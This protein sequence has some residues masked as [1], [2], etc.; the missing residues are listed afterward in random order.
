VFIS[1]TSEIGKFPRDH[2]FVAA[3]RQAVE[4]AGCEPVEMGDFPPQVHPSATVCREKIETCDVFVAL[5]GFRYGSTVRRLPWNRRVSYVEFEWQ[6]AMKRGLPI[7]ILLLDEAA[8][9]PHDLFGDPKFHRRQQRLRDQMGRRHHLRRFGTD[10]ELYELLLSGLAELPPPPPEEPEPTAL[11]PGPVPARRPREWLRRRRYRVAA[12]AA[13][14]TLSVLATVI[15]F[16]PKSPD[17]GC[18]ISTEL[19]VSTSVDTVDVLRD[20]AKKFTVETRVGDCRQAN[21]DVVVASPDAATTKAFTHKWKDEKGG[22]H[23]GWPREDLRQVGPYPHV[24]MP[25]S[26]LEVD[27]AKA[28][29]PAGNLEITFT[30]L[31]SVMSS[32]LVLAV[33]EGIASNPDWRDPSRLSLA[34]VIRRAET[35]TGTGSLRLV[36][37]GPEASTDSLLSTEALYQAKLGGKRLDPRKLSDGGIRLKLHDLEQATV[38][39]GGIEEPG[40]AL[41]CRAAASV[42]PDSEVALMSEQRIFEYNTESPPGESCGTSPRRLTAVY[43]SD[44]APLLD[45][46]FVLV[47]GARWGN[48]KSETAAR[49]FHD[50]LLKDDAQRMLAEKGFRPSG[51]KAFDQVPQDAGIRREPPDSVFVPNLAAVRPDALVEAWKSARRP[52]RVLFVVDVSGSMAI[53]GVDGVTPLD[54]A[55]PAI[56]SA[57]DLVGDADQV[58]LWIFT[59][60]LDGTRDYRE[61]VG[62]GPAQARGTAGTRDQVQ[63][64]LAGLH[65]ENGDTG[66]FDTIRDGIAALR[67]D[68]APAADT[69]TNNALVVFTD[70]RNDDPGGISAGRLVGELNPRESQPVRV[71]ILAFGE[72]NCGRSDLVPLLGGGVKCLDVTAVGV[73]KA[74]ERVGAG[75]WGVD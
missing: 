57:L 71:D 72:A 10:R 63:Q 25:R 62:L 29:R 60:K 67:A 18:G 30:P 37:D 14:A 38:P 22:Q 59:T 21:V 3:A 5:V 68:K 31:T 53:P 73:G 69:E 43:P 23:V 58:G 70:A 27:R 39:G 8:V 75:L 28:V 55:K 56:K 65:R 66:L 51:G 4:D 16:F 13:V 61:L 9:V 47:G 49:K 74:V 33:P 1:H 45:H 54:A 20:L 19:V 2:S 24:W 52:A 6:A 64:A 42:E 34:E 7:L 11:E 26:S 15:K 44:G 35:V 46:P 32:Y 41:G 36:R 12:V 40:L 17:S 50:F 48:R